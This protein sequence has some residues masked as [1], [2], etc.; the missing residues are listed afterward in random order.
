MPLQI[1]LLKLDETL[2]GMP[3]NSADLNSLAGALGSIIGYLGAEAAEPYLFERL[4]WPQ[5]FYNANSLT[6]FLGSAL[7]MPMGGPL[8]RAALEVLDRF[9]KKGLYGGRQ[10]G[11]MLGTAFYADTG[12]K[13]KFHGYGGTDHDPQIRN[14]LWIN[15]LR[16]LRSYSL[17]G[18]EGT[19]KGADVEKHESDI[20]RAAQMVY[21]L[22]LSVPEEAQK[23]NTKFFCEDNISLATPFAMVASEASA[24]GC[25]LL[26]LLAEQ[27]CF[28]FAA[29][30]CLPLF[31]K[32]LSIIC[33][34]RREPAIPKMI[35]GQESDFLI[36]VDDYDHGFP[37]ISGP[38]EVVRQ[39][40]RHWGHPIRKSRLDRARENMSM[41]LVF[42]F[43]F[44][45]PIGLLSMLWVTSNV[46][47]V[48]LAY[49]MYVIVV[50]HLNRLIGFE[51]LGR[52]E[53]TM[54]RELATNGKLVLH[55]ANRGFI[56]AELNHYPASRIRDG[57]AKINEIA[58]DF[59]AKVDLKRND[60]NMSDASTLSP[61]SDKGFL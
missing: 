38:E 44:Y 41:A 32:L 14:G 1:P 7:L 2:F 49:Q 3:S 5:R 56:L 27:R 26:I 40:S 42:G 6:T 12:L 24:I 10:R 13:F 17:R 46:Q 39:F 15:V 52:L 28:W 51:G 36:E 58:R 35:P 22:K 30:M 57:H 60:S 29:Y 53:D 48:W 50:M 61:V 33:A 21:H 11:H 45:F 23:K 47:I 37:L 54:A 4:L 19:K 31:L 20:Q 25:A 8:H 59:Y 9:R 16:S 55:S 18:G 34:V 43:V